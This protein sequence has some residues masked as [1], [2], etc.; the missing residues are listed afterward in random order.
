[1]KLGEKVTYTSLTGVSLCGHVPVQSAV[2]VPGGFGTELEQKWAKVM[3]FPGCTGSWQ[4]G[5]R[6]RGRLDPGPSV[7]RGFSCALWLSISY[8]TRCVPRHWSRSPDDGL[9]WFHLVSVYPAPSL[10]H[11]CPREWQRWSEVCW[12]SPWCGRLCLWSG[13]AH[14][15]SPRSCS[16]GPSLMAA[17]PHSDILLVSAGSVPLTAHSAQHGWPL[18]PGEWTG[19]RGAAGASVGQ[20]THR[21][22]SKLAE[23]WKESCHPLNLFQEQERVR[24]SGEES[25]S[26]VSCRSPWV[27]SSCR[28]MTSWGSP[29]A[30]VPSAWCSWVSPGRTSEPL[31]L[32]SWG[33]QLSILLP[34]R[35]SSPGQ[36]VTLCTKCGSCDCP[37]KVSV[38]LFSSF[39]GS[40][41]PF[42]IS[43]SLSIFLLPF[44]LPFL[45]FFYA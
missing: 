37:G 5:G 9:N 4:F 23:S 32:S 39:P 19:S 3:P 33:T 40:W 31:F 18:A 7:S 2:C 29:R 27:H 14:H 43:F 6:L 22:P 34:T 44:F 16:L 41:F 10:W 38:D 42:F 26:W 36:C 15:Q 35:S 8:W 30:A 17:L 20:G 11:L 12:S 24:V 13:L 21:L 45:P 25:G 1:M 28:A